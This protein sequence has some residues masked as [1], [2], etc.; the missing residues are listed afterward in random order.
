MAKGNIDVNENCENC[1]VTDTLLHYF[2]DCE[3]VTVFWKNAQNWCQR[4]MNVWFEPAYLTILF[5]ISDG[6]QSKE[7]LYAM[8]FIILQAKWFI[9]RMK[10]DKKGLYMT[11]FLKHLKYVV[12][13]EKLIY[14]RNNTIDKYRNT[15]ANLENIL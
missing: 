15:I 7:E 10:L 8:N 1:N 14:Y 9:H 13:I 11:E 4:S 3:K 6:Y 2:L 5:G 12:H